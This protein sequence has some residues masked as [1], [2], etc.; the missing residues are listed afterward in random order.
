V[1]A[2]PQEKENLKEV[3]FNYCEQVTDPAYD[4]EIT[5]LQNWQTPQQLL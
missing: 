4:S 3:I 2:D 5:S 1:K